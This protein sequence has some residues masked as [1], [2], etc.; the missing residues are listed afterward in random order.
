MGI[1]HFP[2]IYRDP[3]VTKVQE[4]E[5]NVILAFQEH[6]KKSKSTNGCTRQN[7]TIKATP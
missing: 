1:I 5:L 7:N 4:E 3:A 6:P 2:N